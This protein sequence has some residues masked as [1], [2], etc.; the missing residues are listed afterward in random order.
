MSDQSETARQFD[1]V[2]KPFMEFWNSF[3]EQTSESTSKLFDTYDGS[4]DSPKL[5]REQLDAA[6]ESMDNY[7]R[8]P[9][10]LNAIKQNIDAMIKA[11][12]QLND[13]HK[14]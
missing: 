2:M 8:S 14:E 1:P 12:R 7:L 13:L 5:N 3:L 10:F 11:K 9:E 6:R 4:A